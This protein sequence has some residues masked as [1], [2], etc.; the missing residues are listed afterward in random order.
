MDDDLSSGVK[1]PNSSIPYEPNNLTDKEIEQQLLED[2]F[3]QEC[4]L[5]NANFKLAS[6]YSKIG[7]L[8]QA[9][10]M[11]D[12]L[13]QI[14]PDAEEKARLY[15]TLG[16]FM[17]Q[18]NNF[19]TA[20]EFYQK[21][22]ALE[23]LNINDWY[24]IHNNLGYSLNTLGRYEEGERYCR[25]AIQIDPK[26][27]NSYKNLA[28]SLEGQCL[29]VEAVENYIKAILSNTLDVRSIQ[30]LKDL[31]LKQPHLLKDNPGLV[32][33]LEEACKSGW[34]YAK[35]KIQSMLDEFN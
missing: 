28:I 12:H 22:Y 27:Y 31:L 14:T 23:P 2:I 21:A 8:D 10:P 29:F 13:M 11:V 26:R 30:H 18:S 1:V 17:E 3:N 4:I 16:Q 34:G 5:R 24:L 32:P 25:I 6:Y 33:Q 9:I 7:K 20:I 19:P 15:L 35:Y